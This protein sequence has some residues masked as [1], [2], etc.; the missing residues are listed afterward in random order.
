M[1]TRTINFAQRTSATAF[2]RFLTSYRVWNP[3]E[4]APRIVPTPLVFVSATSWDKSTKGLSYFCELYAT[5]GYTCLDVDLPVP[6]GATSSSTRLM[7]TFESG[8]GDVVRSSFIPFPPVFIARG[9]ACLI[10]QTYI[11]SHP[12]SGLVLLSPPPNNAAVSQKLLPS[13]LQE[14]NF[15]PKFPI[16]IVST[17]KEMEILRSQ[18]R[19]A[20]DSNVDNIIV[21]NVEGHESCTKIEQWLDEIGI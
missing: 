10:T 21:Q 4:H 2:K 7:E 1:L 6:P 14:F 20:Q 8:L 5:K 12:A 9:L 13:A 18:N 15:E 11:S 16:C 19:L 17:P 3:S